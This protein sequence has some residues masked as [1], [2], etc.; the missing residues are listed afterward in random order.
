[1]GVTPVCVPRTVPASFTR[2]VTGGGRWVGGP[3]PNGNRALTFGA[4][5][6]VYAAA[7][8]ADPGVHNGSTRASGS[9]AVSGWLPRNFTHGTVAVLVAVAGAALGGGAAGVLGGALGGAAAG[10]LAGALAGVLGGALGGVAAGVLAGVLGGALGGVA[11][12]VLAGVLGA[13]DGV[14]LGARSISKP[15]LGA[16][17]GVDGDCEGRPR[18]RRAA[19]L[20]EARCRRGIALP[21]GT[22]AGVRDAVARVACASLMQT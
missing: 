6:L 9:N 1:V 22:R 17:V 19:E 14:P 13:G 18:R 4:E 15:G 2:T 16:E 3:L 10:V 11:A 7:W 12:G 20:S 8:V 5:P 21:P